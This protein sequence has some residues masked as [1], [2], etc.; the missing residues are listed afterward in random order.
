MT[1]PVSMEFC[2]G[3]AGMESLFNGISGKPSLCSRL[4]EVVTSHMTH[5]PD[6]QHDGDSAPGECKPSLGGWYPGLCCCWCPDSSEPGLGAMELR[7]ERHQES[8]EQFTLKV[9]AKYCRA[10]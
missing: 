8:P 10:N 7:G 9:T 1:F 3:L 4:E 5:F 6:P 2:C